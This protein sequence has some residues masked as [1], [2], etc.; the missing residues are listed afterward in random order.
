MLIIAFFIRK[1]NIT[2][3]II[4]IIIIYFII[5][6]INNKSFYY[7]QIKLYILNETRY[8]K[9]PVTWHKA[10]GQ[11]RGN[12]QNEVAFTRVHSTWC[13]AHRVWCITPGA[14]GLVHNT[15]TAIQ[16]T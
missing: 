4:I 10:R 14:W 5:H 13:M 6:F 7:S 3:T 11:F 15:Q 9:G 8:N 1:L 16:S 2:Q 12:F